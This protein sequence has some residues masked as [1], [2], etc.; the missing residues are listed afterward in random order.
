[1]NR[2][3][4]IIALLPFFASC[5][6]RVIFTNNLTGEIALKKGET[7]WLP[8]QEDAPVAKLSIL[9]DGTVSGTP[10]DIKAASSSVDYY[11][12]FTARVNSVIKVYGASFQSKFYRKLKRGGIVRRKTKLHFHPHSGWINDPNGLFYKDGVWHMYYQYNPFGAK[13][14]NMSWGHAT[15][16]DLLHWVE[17]DLALTP[18]SLGMI[19]SGSAICVGDSVVAL[20]TSAGRRQSQSIAFSDDSGQTFVKPDYNP[21]LESGLP[22]FRDPKV[23]RYGDGWRLVLAAGNAIEIYSSKNLENWSFE[24]RFGETVGNH[25]GVWECPDLFELPYGNGTK[26]VMLVSNTRNASHGSAVQYFIGDFDGSVFTPCDNKVRWLDYGR[27]FYAA[28]TWNNAPDGRRVAVAW[29]NNWQYANDIPSVASRGQMSVPRELS[30]IEYDGDLVLRNSPV[31]EVV[32]MLPSRCG[33]IPFYWKGRVE[34]GE[35]LILKNRS[36]EA[37]KIS[38]S[39]GSV[40]VNRRFSG[41]TG[42]HDTYPSIDVAP[43]SRDKEHVIELLVDQN[44]VEI[45]IDEGAVS[46]TE[47]VF[48]GEQYNRIEIW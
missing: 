45:F 36:N 41:N 24:S 15:S 34:E 37:L 46:F 3:A 1:M 9:K 42:F 23:F 38:F 22:D 32:S 16:K 28:A 21:V 8:I 5:N 6:N 48:P 4:F 47:S 7:V 31:S 43:V 40:T 29:A 30:L 33:R 19:F 12:P 27:D 35:E 26:W 18:D 20:Y 10:F 2:V 17:Q 39:S 11:I 44:L 13:W 14:G 25:G